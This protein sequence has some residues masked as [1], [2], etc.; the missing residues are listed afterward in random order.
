[1]AKYAV[2]N[3]YGIS[4]SA[5]RQD[6]SGYA[7]IPRADGEES[8]RRCEVWIRRNDPANTC[9]IVEMDPEDNAKE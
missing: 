7:Y 2:V 3:Q 1:M 4:L 9:A 6:D 5:E 8:Y